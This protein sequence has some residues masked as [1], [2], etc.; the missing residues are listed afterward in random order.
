[1]LTDLTHYRADEATTLAERVDKIVEFVQGQATLPIWL[2]ELANDVEYL[3]NMKRYETN[4]IEAQNRLRVVPLSG[5][6]VGKLA[7]DLQGKKI[8]KYVMHW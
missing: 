5:L 6:L 3:R 8:H 2:R 1:V 4:E 7:R